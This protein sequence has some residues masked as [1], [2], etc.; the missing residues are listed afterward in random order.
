MVIV[1]A[2]TALTWNG[3][4][5]LTF[6]LEGIDHQQERQ[7]LVLEIR[8]RYYKDETKND[9]QS[10]KTIEYLGRRGRRTI[11]SPLTGYHSMTGDEGYN[12]HHPLHVPVT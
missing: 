8:L 3:A 7:A 2:Y 1:D 12:H 4:R 9:D 6:F 11:Y 5:A 10:L